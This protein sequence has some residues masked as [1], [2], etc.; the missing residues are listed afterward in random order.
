MM[1]T[2]SELIERLNS[3]GNSV[4]FDE[5]MQVIST[6]YHYQPSSFINGKVVNQAGSN[7]GSCKIF[8]FAKLHNL[9]EQATL[10]CF[11]LFYRDDVLK[12]PKGNDHGN[13]RSFIKNGWA[14]I[15]FDQVVLTAKE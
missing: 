6:N 13:I 3:I 1:L 4:E 15:T 14:G 7:E 9:S 12:H 5:V 10:N 11:G 8:A 2:I